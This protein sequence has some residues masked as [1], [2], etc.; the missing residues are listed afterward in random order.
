MR[1]R[2]FIGVICGAA[3][4]LPCGAAAQQAGKVFLRSTGKGEKTRYLP[5][6]PGS[7][8]LIHDYFEAAGHGRTKTAATCG[9]MTP[10]LTDPIAVI[11]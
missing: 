10:A 1:R 7:N 9:T 3:L 11:G 6:H 2:D 8:Q 5:L 4:A